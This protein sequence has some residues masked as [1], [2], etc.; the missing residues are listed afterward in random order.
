MFHVSLEIKLIY[1][2]KYMWSLPVKSFK[3]YTYAKWPMSKKGIHHSTFALT[4]GFGVGLFVVYTVP[5]VFQQITPKDCSNFSP[6]MKSIRNKEHISTRIPTR[7]FF[8]ERTFIVTSSYLLLW[9]LSIFLLIGDRNVN[10]HIKSW[11]TFDTITVWCCFGHRKRLHA[12]Y[13]VY[14]KI[15]TDLY[16]RCAEII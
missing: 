10:F 13:D 16:E 6:S 9:I 11:F 2:E 12:G 1:M 15:C 3:T 7:I 4:R 5:V 8:L 14:V